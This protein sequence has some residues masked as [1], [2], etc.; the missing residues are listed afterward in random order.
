MKIRSLEAIKNDVI[1][2]REKKITQLDVEPSKPAE[3]ENLSGDLGVIY[4]AILKHKIYIFA[5]S[6][7]CLLVVFSILLV[8]TPIYQSSIKLLIETQNAKVVNVEEIYGVGQSKE[9]FNTQVE[10]IKSRDV[11]LK[12]IKLL[13]L[14]NVPEF[15]P[16][17][18]ESVSFNSILDIFGVDNTKST[19][20]LNDED[21]LAEFIIDKFESRMKVQPIRLSQLVVISFESEDKMLSKKAANAIANAYIEVDRESKLSMTN[22]ANTWLNS[23]L[24]GLGDKLIQAENSLQNYREKMGVIDINGSVQSISAQQIS[25][26]SQRLINERVK[27]AELESAVNQIKNISNGDYT[28]VPAVMR[29]EAVSLSRAH[30]SEVE[31]KISE[32]KARYGKDH[33]KIIAAEAELQSAKTDTRAQMESVVNSLEHEYEILSATVNSLER[34]LNVAKASLQSVNR[35]GT[36]LGILE[37][38]VASNKQIYETFLNRAKQTGSTNDLQADVARVVDKGA[39]GDK[40]KPKKL[41]SLLAT[42]FISILIGSIA[43]IWREKLDN[44]IKGADDA[45]NKLGV[46]VLT[47]LPMQDDKVDSEIAKLVVSEPDSLFAEGI[48]TATTGILLANLENEHKVIMV[49]SSVAGEGKTSFS[50]NISLSLASSR[51]VLLIDCDMRRPK[52]AD[53]ANLKS[54]RVGLANVLIGKADLKSVLV[55]VPDTNLTILPVGVI[56]SAPLDLINSARFKKLLDQLRKQYDMIVIDSPPVGLVSDAM[57]LM[58]LVDAAIYVVK[59]MDTPVPIIQKG[60]KQIL[61]QKADFIGVVLNQLDFKASQLYY[62]EYTPYSKYGYKG[63]GY[64]SEKPK[65]DESAIAA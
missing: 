55:S 45:E 48:R 4:R 47:S 39:L 18:K 17:P 61:S 59:C 32:I 60:I 26:I 46:P 22:E 40:V 9:Y 33:P 38:Q 1:E 42:L 2:L 29:S 53:S 12:A 11:M 63:Y 10:V 5:F 19:E 27:K 49:T 35:G 57:A 31:S 52:V 16:R 21:V 65:D 62:G 24:K 56:P 25:D 50:L 14:W 58:P 34:S 20:N 23:R 64:T 15:D 3:K 8:M 51:N 7:M 28:S 44:T 43:A 54:I 6:A 41:L 36:Q 37:R 13:K 30:E